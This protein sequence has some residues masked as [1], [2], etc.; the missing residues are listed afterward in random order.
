M[1]AGSGTTRKPRA[2]R[3]LGTV[4]PAAL[5]LAAIGGGIAYS[6]ITV[7]G[8]D[9]TAPTVLWAE[10][11]EPKDSGKD[12]AGKTGAGRADT[13]L[14][15]L[16]L[17]VPDDFRLGPDSGQ[18]GNDSELSGKQATAILK[19]SGKGLTGKKRREFGKYVEKLRLKGVATRTYARSTNDL[20]IDMTITQMDN[21]TAVREMYRFQTRL[22]DEIGIFRDGPAIKGA[23]A[24]CYL[25]PADKK[26]KLDG[27]S[28]VA[29]D[30]ELFVS[31]E[32]FGPE[33]FSKSSAAKL[34][35]K[36]LDH[37]ASPGEYV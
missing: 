10:D 29:I 24:R 30:G 35:R 15:K 32:A 17:P 2:R 14:S 16:L 18:Y 36:Q 7:D 20:V 8:A 13:E 12:P 4:L 19:S 33:P 11:A 26:S 21:K 28:C 6:V 31:M 37:I 1:A 23:K 25:M 34:L 5:V 9:R 3:L 27:M 22:F